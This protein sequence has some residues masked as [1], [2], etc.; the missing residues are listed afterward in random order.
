MATEPKNKPKPRKVPVQTRS[1][2][3]VEAIL[4][5]TARI[6]E[7]EGLE[8]VTTNRVAE[9]AGVSIGSLYQY[10][11][12]RD[13]ILAELVRRMRL[14]MSA[15]LMKASAEAQDMPLA[16]A[17]PR[18]MAAAVHQYETEPRLT[19]ALEQAEA[20][21]PRDPDVLA[22]RGKVR[23][24]MADCLRRRGVADPD[25]AVADLVAMTRGI[26]MMAVSGRSVDYG[27]LRQ[28]IE[29]A[30]MG[31]LTYDASPVEGGG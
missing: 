2:A 22:E 18:L 9:R 10:F 4:E 31:Y 3:T 28:R 16:E 13:A 26:V 29:R 6:L 11:P 27:A 15:R 12:S 8:A 19:A 17:V 5:A 20:R 30:A 21:L 24:A 14:S 23:E 7:A 25:T 1:R